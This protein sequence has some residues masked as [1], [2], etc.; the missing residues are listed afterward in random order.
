LDGKKKRI[1]TRI[2]QR[3][4][5]KTYMKIS[6]ELLGNKKNLIPAI[7][8]MRWKE[9]GHPPES[10]DLQWWIDISA[11]EAGIE[12]LPITWVAIDRAENAVGAVGLS[13][14]DV[15]RWK[16]RSPWIVGMIVQK[17]L[18]GK[19]IG[20][21]LLAELEKW[22]VSRGNNE[23]WV[24]TGDHAVDFYRKLGMEITETFT[25]SEW[26]IDY[27][28]GDITYILRKKLAS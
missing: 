11:K 18:R 9:W 14:Y 23:V 6:V 21:F 28:Q 22:I 26:D 2:E 5:T 13:V 3:Y 16:D 10:E 1:L 12:S 15:T 4:T 20:S 24:A 7:G 19:G 8:E 27:I 17:N 25:L